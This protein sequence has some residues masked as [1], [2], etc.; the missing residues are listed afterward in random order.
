MKILSRFWGIGIIVLG[1]FILSPASLHAA[2]PPEVQDTVDTKVTASLPFSVVFPNAWPK[3]YTT[4]SGRIGNRV[5]YDAD[6][7]G[8]QDEGEVGIPGVQV[9]LYANGRCEGR[10]DVI[11]VTDDRGEYL[12]DEVPPGT[13]SLKFHPLPG[14]TLTLPHQGQDDAKD[15]DALSPSGCTGSIVITAGM[16]DMSW[17]AG[18]VGA[19][20]V[21]GRVWV[22]WDGDGVKDPDETR[23]VADVPIRVTG[24]NSIGVTVDVTV[25][26]S[27]T[28]TYAVGF[29]APGTYTLAAPETVEAWARTSPSP[30]RVTLKPAHMS[31]LDVDFGYVEHTVVQ[32][33]DFQVTSTVQ[34]VTLLWSIYVSQNPTPRFRVWRREGRGP[35]ALI[36][37]TWVER[38][39]VRGHIAYYEYAD[40]EVVPGSH[41]EYRVESDIGAFFGPWPVTVPQVDDGGSPLMRVCCFMPWVQGR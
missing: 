13:Y 16:S 24:R 17:D 40:R 4:S 22:D 26:T 18:M 33:V 37:A 20:R 32:L 21:G 38:Q 5:W 11:A 6:H 1:L 7:D 31:R 14:L 36:S 19:G 30:L 3:H 12:F 34:Q 8:L 28:G 23:G 29:L 2:T 25:T 39:S 41:Y 27:V 35:W 15:S 9:D 10:P